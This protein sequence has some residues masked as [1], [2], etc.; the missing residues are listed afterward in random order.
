MPRFATVY[1][2]IAWT[3]AASCTCS[4]ARAAPNALGRSS[5]YRMP[6]EWLRT[7]WSTPTSRMRLMPRRPCPSPTE[8][9][10]SRTH[11]KHCRKP[12]LLPLQAWSFTE[13]VWLASR[14]RPLQPPHLTSRLPWTAWRLNLALNS[15][16]CGAGVPSHHPLHLPQ[17][18]MPRNR[19]GQ[20][21]WRRLGNASSSIPAP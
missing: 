4:G 19:G 15:S 14:R 11:G 10:A 12:A 21:R 7:T 6:S 1:S 16:L 13:G 8:G 18:N 17:M 9:W 3:G 5:A 2:V 20:S